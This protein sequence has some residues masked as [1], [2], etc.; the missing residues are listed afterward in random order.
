MGIPSK[1]QEDQAGSPALFADLS[2]LHD[3]QLDLCSALE[4]LADTLPDNVNMQECLHLARM[5]Y[6]TIKTAHAFEEEK[7]FPYLTSKFEN[8]VDP[9]T[10]DRLHCEH[11]EDESFAC[12]LQEALLSLVQ[13][14]EWANYE[15]IGYMLRGFFEGLRRHIAFEREMLG[16]LIR[17]QSLLN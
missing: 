6:P 10:L 12:E 9:Q 3:H 15:A 17:K 8:Q 4:K 5:I 14:P 13:E 7:L 2:S 16:Q 11:W 1:S